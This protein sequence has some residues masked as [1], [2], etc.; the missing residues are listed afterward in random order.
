[1]ICWRTGK[2]YVKW[3]SSDSFHLFRRIGRISSFFVGSPV[4]SSLGCHMLKAASELKSNVCSTS[5][6]LCQYIDDPDRRLR[7][8]ITFSTILCPCRRL[9]P[10]AQTRAMLKRPASFFSP[11]SWLKAERRGKS[12]FG[13]LWFVERFWLWHSVM[14]PVNIPWLRRKYHMNFPRMHPVPPR[15]LLDMD[16]NRASWCHDITR[17][18]H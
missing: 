8:N 3:R 10:L 9:W 14:L 16:L 1:M 15:Y 4:R 11:G 12:L 17:W 6:H 2:E 7:Y 5:Y 18:A 13:V